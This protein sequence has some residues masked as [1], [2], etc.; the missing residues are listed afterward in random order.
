MQWGC[1][2]LCLELCS[3]LWASNFSPSSPVLCVHLASLPVTCALPSG[4]YSDIQIFLKG[5]AKGSQ[6]TTPSKATMCGN[7]I[8]FIDRHLGCRN[9]WKGK[10]DVWRCQPVTLAMPYPEP[11]TMREKNEWCLVSQHTHI[12]EGRDCKDCDHTQKNSVCA[13]SAACIWAV[14][15]QGQSAQEFMASSGWS[16]VPGLCQQR[17]SLPV[18]VNASP[19][20]KRHC[21]MLLEEKSVTAIPF[22]QDNHIRQRWS[23]R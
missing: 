22:W 5:V 11:L 4:R 19:L 9:L 3:W 15:P 18:R 21:S 17:A 1:S 13:Y 23:G 20:C 14:T 6:S 10:I 2:H 16:R 7:V 8:N 12:S